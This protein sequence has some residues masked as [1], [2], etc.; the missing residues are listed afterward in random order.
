MSCAPGSFFKI[1]LDTF[2]LKET[3]DEIEALSI[4]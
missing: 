3:F 1:S 2:K 4:K